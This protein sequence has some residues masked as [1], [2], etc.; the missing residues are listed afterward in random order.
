MSEPSKSS[1]LTRRH[2]LGLGATGALSI[3]FLSQCK[4][5]KAD[6]KAVAAQEWRNR[7]HD[8]AYRQLGRTGLMVS[9]VLC[10][11]D[12]VRLDN[13]KQVEVAIERGL[14]YLDMAPSYGN[15]ECEKA[16]AKVID[17]SSKRE[18]VFM[19]TKV[20]AF[21]GVRFRMYEDIYKGLPSGKQEAI[22]KKAKAMR[23]DRGVEKPGYFLTYW[24]GQQRS[25]DPSFLCNAMMEDYAHLVEGSAKFREVMIKSVEASLKRAGVEYFDILMCPHGA[26][27]AEEVQIPEIH[28]TY[29]ELKRS[30]KV[31]FLG[32]STHNDPA[33]VLKAAAESD[34]FD[35][36]MA[37]YNVINGGYM[38]D[39]IRY[40]HSK[41]VGIIGMKVAMAV[42][43]QHK[44]LQP[45]P[46]WRIQKVDRIVPG[47]DKPPVKAYTWALQNPRI[48]AVI[49]NL[50]NEEYVSENLGVA[51]KVV[52]LQPG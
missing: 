6:I 48:A 42:A 28:A 21:K 13:Y 37:A 31:R 23:E 32:V 12:P 34:Q 14:N 50:W 20:S 39:A 2:F 35:V 46:N 18:K 10:G 25:N 38:D 16:Y 19:T 9:E 40:A 43:T 45:I 24:P 26:N 11:G 22:N 41:G 7:Q 15:G 3:P 52:E 47:E 33:G 36:V 51:G 5:R 30:G 17:S 29:E 4:G 27:C 8:M 44:S 1:R 49:S